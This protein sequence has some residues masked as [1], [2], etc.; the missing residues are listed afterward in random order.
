MVNYYF[1]SIMYILLPVLFIIM[2]LLKFGITPDYIEYIIR[3]KK[4]Q[5]EKGITMELYYQIEKEYDYI[6]PRLDKAR[7]WKAAYILRRRHKK[8]DYITLYMMLR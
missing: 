8:R 4:E 7:E 3:I 5:R 1:G 6:V 2:I